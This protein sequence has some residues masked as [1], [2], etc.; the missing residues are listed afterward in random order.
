MTYLC[1][2]LQVD[3]PN[4]IVTDFIDGIKRNRGED[5]EVSIE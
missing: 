4:T 5:G 2:I 3:K 1:I